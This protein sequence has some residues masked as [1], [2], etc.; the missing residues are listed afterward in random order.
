MSE[1]QQGHNVA[2]WGERNAGIERGGQFSPLCICK[3][4]IAPVMGG[5]D[6]ASHIPAAPELRERRPAVGV[7]FVRWDPI[8]SGSNAADQSVA[9]F[10]AVQTNVTLAVSIWSARCWSV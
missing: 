6:V 8:G 5:P 7:D 1:D 2:R 4:G 9:G 3:D 10:M